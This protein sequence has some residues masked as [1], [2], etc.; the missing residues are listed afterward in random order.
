MNFICICC[1]QI[2]FT[3][4]LSIVTSLSALPSINLIALC[5]FKNGSR[6]FLAYVA[7][8]ALIRI[9]RPFNLLISPF[10]RGA[11]LD[12]LRLELAQSI[13]TLLLGIFQV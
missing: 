10:T 1:I 11:N 4:E 6:L 12:C 13:A 2:T 7:C 8:L 3:A 9:Y 5:S